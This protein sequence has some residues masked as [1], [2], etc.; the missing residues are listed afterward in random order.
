M[1]WDTKIDGKCIYISVKYLVNLNYFVLGIHA[2]LI[3]ESRT[4]RFVSIT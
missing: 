2:V 4:N 3:S 1:Q